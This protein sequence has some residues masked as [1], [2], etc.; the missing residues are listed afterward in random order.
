MLLFLL[1]FRSLLAAPE[2]R[3]LNGVIH[4]R[5]ARPRRTRHAGLRDLLKRDL[6]SI[7]KSI[8]SEHAPSCGGPYVKPI[9]SA[10]TA[11]TRSAGWRDDR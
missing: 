9:C 11:D 5:G 3:V 2:T 6:G 4:G 1:S 10:D 7:L 8:S